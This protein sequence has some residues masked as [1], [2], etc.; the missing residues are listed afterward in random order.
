MSRATSGRAVDRPTPSPTAARC[1][2][3]EVGVG[4]VIEPTQRPGRSGAW[5]SEPAIGTRSS[6]SAQSRNRRPSRGR[7]AGPGHLDRAQA[8]VDERPQG[9]EPEIIGRVGQPGNA[10]RAR[11]SGAIA[12]AQSSRGLAR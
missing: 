6:R 3:V 1:E 8:A 12:S 2:G 11:G 4:V 5:K 9:L 7:D 10:A